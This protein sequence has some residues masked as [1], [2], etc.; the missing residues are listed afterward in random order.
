[1]L[2]DI[3]HFKQINDQ[4]GHAIGDEILKH[5]A[6]AMTSTLRK[7]DF[8]ARIGGEEFALVLSDLSENEA[9][10]IGN[11]VRRAIEERSLISGSVVVQATVSGGLYYTPIGFKTLMG[12][13]RL[14]MTV[15]TGPRLAD[16]IGSYSQLNELSPLSRGC[17]RFACEASRT[18]TQSRS[19]A[20]YPSSSTLPTAGVHL[21]AFRA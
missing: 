19:V 7:T 6:E 4:F 14:Q 17:G 13:S 12:H 20:E 8:A 9:L 10:A 3:D 18:M 11:R 16:G 1:M 15:F 21:V 5:C 2:L